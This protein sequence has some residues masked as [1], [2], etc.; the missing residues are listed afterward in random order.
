MFL[1]SATQRSDDLVGIAMPTVPLSPLPPP[2]VSVDRPQPERARVVSIPSMAASQNTFLTKPSSV[3]AAS[4]AEP[5]EN[6]SV[7]ISERSYVSH[8]TALSITHGDLPL[9]L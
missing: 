2:A 7:N 5:N 8:A 3:D 9:D 4:G 6:V 1:P